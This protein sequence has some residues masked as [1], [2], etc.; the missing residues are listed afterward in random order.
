MELYHYT[1]PEGKESI[2]RNGFTLREKHKSYR[3][4]QYVEIDRLLNAYTGVYRKGK[5]HLQREQAHYFSLSFDEAC[6]YRNK[7]AYV[8]SVDSQCLNNGKLFVANTL[9]P[10]AL[11]QEVHGRHR[12]E[13]ISAY[14]LRYWN[15]LFP[16]DFYIQNQEQIAEVYRQL[17]QSPFIPEVLYYGDIPP[18][19]VKATRIEGITN[20]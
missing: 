18:Q 3:A 6:A 4:R 13:W 9:I 7:T 19:Y 12:Q 17:L 20:S 14:Q 15:D 8:I 10:E 11:Y 16:F 5:E 1:T 2:T